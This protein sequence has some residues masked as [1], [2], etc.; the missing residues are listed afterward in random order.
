MTDPAE[1]WAPFEPSPAR[2]WT[3]PLAAHLLR[4]AGFGATP[5]RLEAALREG[6]GRTVER[7]V[8]ETVPTGQAF[9]ESF[10]QLEPARP[11]SP[12]AWAAWWL[13]RMIETPDPLGERLTLFWHGAFAV[14]ADQVG[15]VSL[16]ASRV[17]RF[18]RCARS[19]LVVLTQQVL[20]DPATH[21]AFGQGANRR[22]LPNTSLARVLLGD[23]LLGPEGVDT[24]TVHEA[25]RALT[26][27]FVI[28]SRLRFIPREFD[29]EPKSLW[30]QR[31]P[32]NREDLAR[33]AVAR[34]EA[35]SRWARA[36][37][38]GFVAED[39]EPPVGWLAPLEER[40]GPEGRLTDALTLIF[41]SRLFYSPQAVGRRVK[42]P[43]ELAVGLAR[44]LGGLIPTE[45]LAGDLARLGQDLA[46]PPTPRGWPTGADWLTNQIW[47][48][49]QELLAALLASDGRYKGR[50]HRAQSPGMS[51]GPASGSAARLVA[52][53]APTTD[54]S[55]ARDLG[56]PL[57]E[58]VQ[59]LVHDPA[60][61]LA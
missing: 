48:L 9:N 21:L 58:L 12:V 46:A 47:P 59:R 57:P 19:S 61:Q 50:L 32:W 27:W 15:G 28:R 53:L 16:L 60:F 18:R 38:R 40:L 44:T 17:R 1:A 36:L 42:S 31:G 11:G 35:R 24:T 37:Y 20:E 39:H 2:P 6:P 29:P 55:T 33:L 10:D 13:R 51:A 54:S 5:D 52:L 49:R 14:R 23:W 3:P 8:H 25:A 43:V 4:R 22:A 34:P 7:L 45:P 26:G 56:R 30:G 41:R